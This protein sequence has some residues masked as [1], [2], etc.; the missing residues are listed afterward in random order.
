MNLKFKD[1][2]KEI[3]KEQGLSQTMLAERLNI[4]RSAVAKW[5]LG[6]IEP[7]LTMLM[8]ICVELG[9]SADFLIGLQDY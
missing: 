3:R 7:N 1:R 2:L 8:K 5:E 6:E 4:N 9:V